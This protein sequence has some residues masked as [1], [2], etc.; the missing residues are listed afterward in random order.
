[1][2]QKDEEFDKITDRIPEKPIGAAEGRAWRTLPATSSI[3]IRTLV[4]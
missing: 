1:L 2:L 4:C 3:A